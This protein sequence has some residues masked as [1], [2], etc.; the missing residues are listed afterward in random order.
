MEC[1]R[2]FDEG[3]KCNKAYLLEDRG[4]N[5]LAKGPVAVVLGRGS[6]LDPGEDILGQ[7]VRDAW[8]IGGSCEEEGATWRT[9]AEPRSPALP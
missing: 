7:E 1:P 2:A 5:M 3:S 8:R 9:R 6:H 4:C